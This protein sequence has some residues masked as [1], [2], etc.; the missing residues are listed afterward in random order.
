MP[1]KWYWAHD[2]K[3]F[4]EFENPQE[5]TAFNII[6]PVV[7]SAFAEGET[8]HVLVNVQLCNG[9]PYQPDL[10]F[11]KN[12]GAGAVDLK[13]YSGKIDVKFERRGYLEH[14]FCVDETGTL[15]SHGHG[16]M[17][18][19]EF[20][21]VTGYSDVLK[22][23]LRKECGLEDVHFKTFFGLC[24]TG[25]KADFSPA[26][27]FI[28]DNRNDPRLKIGQFSRLCVSEEL[29]KEI[30]N[31]AFGRIP[32]S[33]TPSEGQIQNIISS[34]RCLPRSFDERWIAINEQVHRKNSI[35]VGRKGTETIQDVQLSGGAVVSERHLLIIRDKPG[36]VRLRDTSTNGTYVNSVKLHHGEILLPLTADNP[37][38]LG[39]LGGAQLVV[40]AP[41]PPQRRRTVKQA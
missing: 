5:R 21:Q 6:Q 34:M 10:L 25:I 18:K 22:R 29:G 27:K 20:A 24:F 7:D 11:L 40:S 26:Q 1:V 32:H 16:P 13:D 19:G 33:K 12:D 3:K 31:A 9:I 4:V 8:C 23:L 38:N 39:F 41:T 37:I 15:F 2:G 36:Y 30:K 17:Y 28:S 14:A 35:L